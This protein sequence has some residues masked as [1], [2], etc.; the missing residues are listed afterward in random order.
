MQMW[1]DSSY[2]NVTIFY[3]LSLNAMKFEYFTY[4]VPL[5]DERDQMF[6]VNVLPQEINHLSIY[7]IIL[8]YRNM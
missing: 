8:Y 2:K 4:V 1:S 6:R 7:N 3:F 5:L